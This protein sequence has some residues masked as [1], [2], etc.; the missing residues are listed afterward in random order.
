MLVYE[1]NLTRGDNGKF[2]FTHTDGIINVVVEGSSA[3][4][5]KLQLW[6]RIYAVDGRK[7]FKKK[8]IY[9]LM[10]NAGTTVVLSLYRNGMFDILVSLSFLIIVT[11]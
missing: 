11:V 3:D 4:K 9:S 7:P 2:G 8:N 5:G 10:K 6:D 1:A